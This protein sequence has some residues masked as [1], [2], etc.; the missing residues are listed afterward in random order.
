MAAIKYNIVKA[1]HGHI[2]RQPRLFS[3]SA[4]TS[5]PARTPP[6]SCP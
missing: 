5:R 6:L 3:L 1:G 2:M 4:L